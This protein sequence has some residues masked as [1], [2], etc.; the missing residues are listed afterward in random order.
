MKKFRYITT[1]AISFLFIGTLLS[2]NLIS[3]NELAKKANTISYE[4]L[5]AISQRVKKTVK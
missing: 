5:T 2:Q 4:I 3:V 1:L